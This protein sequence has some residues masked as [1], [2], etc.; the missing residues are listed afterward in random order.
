MVV[1]FAVEEVGESDVLV[2]VGVVAVGRE[3]L[4]GAGHGAGGEGVLV[5]E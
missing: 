1:F 2:A 5:P 4:V 3:G